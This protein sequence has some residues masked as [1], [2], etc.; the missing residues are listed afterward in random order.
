MEFGYGQRKHADTNISRKQPL[1]LPLLPKQPQQQREKQTDDNAGGD[2]QVEPKILSAD[3]DISRQ[4]A[5]RQLGKPR[6]AD[7]DHQQNKSDDYQSFCHLFLLT[8]Q[9]DLPRLCRQSLKDWPPFAQVSEQTGT[10]RRIHF[11]PEQGF[12]SPTPNAILKRDVE[13]ALFFKLAAAP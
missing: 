9:P 4:P 12:I 7:A 10:L 8:D 2:R 3:D 5:Q 13:F 6:P 1:K 11:A